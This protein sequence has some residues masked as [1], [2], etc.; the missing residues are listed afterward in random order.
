MKKLAL[1]LLLIPF[2][3]SCNSNKDRVVSEV[4]NYK[5]FESEIIQNIPSGLSVEDSIQFFQQ[6]VETWIKEKVVLNEAKHVLSLKEQN[7]D[8]QIK[9]YKEKLLIEAYYN[10]I[11]SDSAKFRIS[12]QEIKHFT[13]EFKVSEPIQKNVVR[14]NY[15]KL[16]KKSNVGNKIKDILFNDDKRVAQKAQLISI[17]SD[18]IEYFLD[19]NQWILL[20]YLENDF[21][22]SINNKEALLSDHKNMDVSD[23]QYRYLIVFLDF[24]TQFTSSETTEEFESTKQM[25]LQQKKVNYINNVK[26]SLLEKAIKNGSVLQ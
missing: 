10:K 25:L 17:C 20:E 11:T 24:K 3:Y 5:L 26:K 2:F 4:F 12:D 1:V 18:S 14:V 6:Y 21:P 15:I 8:E 9:N 23:E 7:F 19:D 22:F 16:S 13:K